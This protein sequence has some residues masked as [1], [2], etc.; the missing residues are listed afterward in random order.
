MHRKYIYT[1]LASITS[2]AIPLMIQ[3]YLSRK[4]KSVTFIKDL[5]Q[6][7]IQSQAIGIRPQLYPSPAL[8]TTEALHSPNP[9]NFDLILSAEQHGKKAKAFLID[10]SGYFPDKQLWDNIF[11]RKL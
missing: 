8:R 10:R 2:L 11:Y 6:I 3:F 9:S 4:V 7:S 5:Q 1:G